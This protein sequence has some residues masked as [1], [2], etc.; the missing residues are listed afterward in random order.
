MHQ[1]KA[2]AKTEEQKEEFSNLIDKFNKKISDELA[3]EKNPGVREKYVWLNEYMKRA[4]KSAKKRAKKR[5]S[6]HTAFAHN[7]V[8]L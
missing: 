7:G 1:G 4:K 5:D 8:T 2:N 6:E 3:T